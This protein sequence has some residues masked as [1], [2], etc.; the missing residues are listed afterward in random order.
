M[1]LS[2]KTKRNFSRIIPFGFIWVLLGC[3]FLYIEYAATNGYN[4]TPSSA[5]SLN[6]EIF[7]FANLAVFIVGLLVGV[8][9]INFVNEL[10]AKRSFASKLIFKTLT[11]SVFLFIIITITFPIAASMELHVS[12]LDQQV[13]NKYVEYLKSTTNISTAVQMGSSLFASLFYF[14]ISENLGPGVLLNFFTGRYHK[15]VEEN[16]IFMF[17]DMK[18]STTIAEKLGHITYFNLLKDYYNTFSDPII[19]NKGQVYQYIGDEIVVSWKFS[20]PQENKS[21]IDCFFDMKQSLHQRSAFFLNKYGIAP[22]FKA[23]IHYGNVTTGEIGALKKEIA[24]SGDVLNTTARIQAMCNQL[25]VDLLVS[26]VLLSN[27]ALE[28]KYI[29]KPLGDFELRGKEE[30]TKICT[31]KNK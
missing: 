27:I 20:T 14:E 30:S 12:I 8:I 24:F 28:E 9:E 2:P 18:S 17:L 16:R 7:I 22:A 29:S 21:C 25:K 4:Y 5:I 1:T 19:K 3:V 31:I 13:W 6:W 15:P 11:Y 10:F 23:G 26:E